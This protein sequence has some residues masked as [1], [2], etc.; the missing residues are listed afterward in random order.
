M[1]GDPGQEYFSDGMTEEVIAQSGRLNPRRLGVIARTSSMKYK[2][3]NKGVAEIGRELGVDYILEGS[4]RRASDRVRITAQ[5]IQVKDQTHLW[6]ESYEK[7]LADIFA[8]QSE[9]A[10]RI[11]HSLAVELL[12]ARQAALERASTRNS[13]AYDA[14]LKGRYFWNKRTVVGITTGIQY[15]QQAIGTDPKFARAHAGLAD[16]YT[17]LVEYGWS[18][19]TKEMPKAMAAAGKALEIDQDLAEAHTSLAHAKFCY[20]RN[21]AGAEKGFKR[22]IELNPSYATAHEWFSDYLA[23]MERFEEADAEGR[24]AQQLDP[25]SL[26]ISANR[27]QILYYKRQY[28][29]AV[30]EC[31]RALEMDLNFWFA[32]WVLGCSYLELGMTR[33]A[34]AA[35]QEAAALSRPHG[36][37]I[38]VL[39]SL[40]QAYVTVG[41]KRKALRLA[42]ELKALSQ[43]RYVSPYCHALIYAALGDKD[44]AFAWLEKARQE[45]CSWL[46]LLKVDPRVDAL[47]SEPKFHDLVSRLGLPA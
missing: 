18:L 44:C 7:S 42:D 25:L 19:P 31:L 33:E 34:I 36:G 47:R 12:P 24:Q 45:R 15:L 39:P 5:L 20:E 26:I 4:V 9:V 11:A 28:E 13:C 17:S 40:A 14:Y 30:G 21:W 46:T 43:K 22:A 16:C 6:A 35:L 27:A 37:N 29:R 10:G 1:S 3:T 23:A 2:R 32:H 41:R 8:I 38:N